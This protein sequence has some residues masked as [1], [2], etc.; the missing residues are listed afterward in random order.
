M[1]KSLFN[2]YRRRSGLFV[3]FVDLASSIAKLAALWA[4]G[5]NLGSEV[6]SLGLPLTNKLVEVAAAILSEHGGGVGP[7]VLQRELSSGKLRP[8]ELDVSLGL[9]QTLELEGVILLVIL[10][11]AHAEVLGLEQRGAVIGLS[12]SQPLGVLELRGHREILFFWRAAMAFWFSPSSIWRWRVRSLASTKSFFL[13]E[14]ASL[15]A[16]ARAISSSF[17]CHPGRTKPNNLPSPRS[18]CWWRVQI[19][20]DLTLQNIESR[21]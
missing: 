19:R 1:F 4:A 14:S 7:L 16:R 15:M 9:W 12:A 13:L 8:Q 21:F 17:P 5:V 6:I 20:S 18:S 11:N 3:Q 2:I 10:V